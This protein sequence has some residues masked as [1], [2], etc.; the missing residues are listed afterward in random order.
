M[1]TGKFGS[2]VNRNIYSMGIFQNAF[3]FTL[4]SVEVLKSPECLYFSLDFNYL[5]KLQD[6]EKIRDF[7]IVKKYFVLSISVTRD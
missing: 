5:D 4:I 3:T 1:W 7:K 2:I 6:D